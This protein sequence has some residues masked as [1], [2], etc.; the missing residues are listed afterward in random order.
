MQTIPDSN[1]VLD[2]LLADK[3]WRDW[4]FRLLAQCKAEGALVL[5]PIVFAEIAAEFRSYERAHDTIS[6][7]GFLRDDIPYEAAYL[8][9]RA[10]ISYRARGGSRDRTLPDF[11]IGAHA[12]VKGYRLLTRDQSRYRSYFPN[13]TIIAPDTHP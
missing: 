2:L 6:G 13:L 8:A 11:L 5:T 4:S 1:V 12:A 3:D 9:G 7:L 10:H